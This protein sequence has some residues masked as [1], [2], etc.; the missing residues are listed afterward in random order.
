MLATIYLVLTKT[1][2]IKK[3]IRFQENTGS[4]NRNHRWSSFLWYI[5]FF[6]RQ[7]H[8]EKNDQP[9][10]DILIIINK[11]NLQMKWHIIFIMARDWLAKSR[12][13]QFWW[14]RKQSIRRWRRRR[15]RRQKW[16][17][18]HSSKNCYIVTLLVHSLKHWCAS[19]I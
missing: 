4:N 8:R 16:V 11:Y 17:R 14:L 18:K 10:R 6:L 19:R 2:F 5:V 12:L 3:N 1:I 15:R 7:F 13:T 9:R